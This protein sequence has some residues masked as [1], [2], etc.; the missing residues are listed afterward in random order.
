VNAE[1][2]FPPSLTSLKEL[3]VKEGSREKI[4]TAYLSF[5][6][7]DSDP[8]SLLFNVFEGPNLGHIEL[9]KQ[10]GTAVILVH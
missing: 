4:T 7:A 8:A 9:T 10:P 5:T 6:D 2:R 3:V 1:D